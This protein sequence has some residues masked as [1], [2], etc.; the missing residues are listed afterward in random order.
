MET[1]FKEKRGRAQEVKQS[2]VVKMKR[3]TIMQHWIKTKIDPI[4]ARKRRVGNKNVEGNETRPGRENKA[5]KVRRKNQQ[6]GGRGQE[7]TAD[8]TVTSC[9]ETPC[10]PQTCTAGHLNVFYDQKMKMVSSAV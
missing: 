1:E 8:T 9:S 3:G 5:L 2:H 6:H 4:W 10:G 7:V